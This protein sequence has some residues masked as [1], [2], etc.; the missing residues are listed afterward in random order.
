ME[1]RTMR[2]LFRL[3]VFHLVALFAFTL[4]A[5]IPSPEQ[6]LGFPVGEDR[7]LADWEQVT[8]YFQKLAAAAPD[9]VRFEEIGKSTLGKPFVVVT[10]SSPENM[11]Q[12]AHY[13]QIQ[14]R[15]SDPRGVSRDEAERLI[16]EGKAVVLITC[17]VHSTEVAS[18]QTAMEFVYRLLTENTP[19]HQEILNNVIFLLV[20]SLNPDG[21]DMVVKWY[22]KYVGTPYEGAQPVE[23][24]HHYVGHDDNR[25]WYM[26][27]QVESQL[28]VG[29]IQN[30]WHPEVV[31]DV[32]QMG[33]G[34]A[35]LFVPPFLD[36]VDPNV[37]PLL[38]QETNMLGTS[39]A[40]ALASAG[41][42]GV[43]INAIYDFWTPAR[44]YQA[45]HGGLRVLTESAS[46]RLASPVRVRFEDLD[47]NGLGYNAQRAS[48]NFPDPWRGGEWHLR[49]I[50]DYQ[51]I[52]YEACLHTVAQNREMFVRNFYNLGVRAMNR[53]GGP[54]AFVIPPDQHDLPTAMKMLN[55]LRFGLVEIQRAKQPFAADGMQFPAGSWVIQL[56][57]PY[58]SYARTLLERQKYPDLREYPGG[59]P[60]RPYDVTAQT[61]PLLMGV[62]TLE[63]EQP[64][65]AELEKVDG[66][67]AAPARVDSRARQLLLRSDSDYAF[68]AVNR[69]AKA[70]ATIARLSSPLHNGGHEFPAGTF[71]VSG[72]AAQA[73]LPNGLE[74]TAADVPASSALAVKAPRIGI[75]TSY[76]ASMDEG[77]TRW[78]F[79][80]FE[81]PYTRIYD[82]DVRAGDL[83]SRFDVIVLPDQAV[84]AIVNGNARAAAAAAGE[85]GTQR[86]I[87]DS[88]GGR[89]PEE[90]TGGIGAA[91]VEALNLFVTQGGTLVTLNSAS[92]FAI[93][94]LGVG[95]RNVL[96]GVA[97]KDF[98][99][100]GSIL[101]VDVDPAHPL[102]WGMERDTAIWF[103]HSPAFAPTFDR[104]AGDVV[105]VATYP[106]GNPLMSGWLLGD[107]F[108]QQ[109]A[110]LLD[111]PLGR[112]HVVMFG[113]RPQYRGQSYGTFKLLFNALYYFGPVTQLGSRNQG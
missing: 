103:E 66:P 34:S 62:K 39:M 61:L 30:P 9:R 6:H 37:D 107:Q 64:F 72:N 97:N 93:E 85:G 54:Y 22:R 53:K 1:T 70:G 10:I 31:Y 11:G 57:Q 15:L 67:D 88:Q 25:D 43:A 2:T 110:A 60:K 8:T 75:Y 101:R 73:K 86:A 100:P 52:A 79:D 65:T 104:A 87:G 106:G 41:K 32:H 42:Q 20:P 83:N 55:T 94:R 16:H 74:F 91:G 68:L 38:V 69:L 26:F 36:P 17:T 92:N 23:L 82:K 95:A 63:I 89:V 96:Q 84:N 50:V 5:Q 112:G 99:G 81:F 78:L 29:K 18:T 24:Y 102:A 13:Q 111:A 76:L 77:W 33:T 46:A 98:Y 35:R 48:W 12:L 105:N 113:F 108:L 27:T 14:Q 44:H 71:V 90:F 3:A 59:P 21:Q 51:L 47:Q 7:K 80:Q 49:D 4:Q 40:G 45:Y 28:T 19:E 109:H 58:G 56:N